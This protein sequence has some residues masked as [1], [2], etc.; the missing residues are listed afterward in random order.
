[1][2][3]NELVN[4]HNLPFLQG[5][6]EMGKI[7]R[8]TYWSET[9]LGPA[10]KWPAPLRLATS[11]VLSTPFPMYIAWGSDYIQIY[12]DG[13]RPILGS[14]KHPQAL[15]IST[16]ETFAEIWHIIGSMFDGVMG[17]EAVGFPDFMLPLNRNG[18]VEECF[19]DF[20]Y[21]PIRYEDRIVGGVLVTVIET[22][23]NKKNIS[24]LKESE[25][26]F[27]SLIQHAPVAIANLVGAN[28]VIESANTQILHYWG[29]TAEIIGMP[30][31][32][33]LPELKDQ[34]FL[35]I[36]NDTFTSGQTY[37][38]NQVKS[39]L[40]HEGQL[41][42][43]YFNFIYQP[44][45]GEDGLT[46]SIAVVANEVTELVHARNELGRTYEQVRLSKEAAMLGTFDMDLVKGTMMWDEQCRL[47][48]GIS[49]SNTV[50]YEKDFIPGLHPD[51]RERV[52]GVI[53]NTMNKAVSNGDYDVEY[54]TIGAESQQLR[55]VRAKGK[56]YFND[57]DEPI[58][59]IGSVLDITD[60]KTE[61]LRLNESVTRQA[62]LAA[63][64]DT[65][66]D[67]ILSKTLEGVITSWNKAAERMFGYTE[68]EAIGKH[69]SLIIP[70]SRLSEE[71][72]IIGQIK[73]GNRVDHFETVRVTK[74][75]RKIP[76]S[77]SVSPITD[78][79]GQIIGASKIA[80]D[81][82]AQYDAQQTAMRYTERLEI[83]NT[84]SQ[85]V[86]GEL[87][88][89]VILQKVT[90]ATTRLTG[91]AFG[92]FFYN[93]VDSKGESY[94]LYTLSGAPREA[95]EK[96]GMPRN[97]AIFNP[98]FEGEGIVRSDDITKDPR[99][100]K[101]AP[102]YG[103]P[104]G[105]LPVVS[106]LAVPVISNS[107]N[108][109]GG[110]FFGHPEPRMFTKE[111]ETLVS[112]IAA[113][114]AISI[115]NAKL[116]EEVKA[117]NQKKDEFIGLASHELKT[118]LTSISGYLQIISKL[119]TDDKT[120]QFVNKTVLQVRKLA[121]LVNDLLDVSKIEAGKLQLSV[122]EFDMVKLIEDTNEL[123]RLNSPKYD[124]EFNTEVGTCMVSADSQRIEQVLLNLLNNAIKYSPGAD[125]VVVTLR[126]ARDKVTVGVQDF[127]AGIPLDK[128]VQ[129]FS[130]FYR[131]E[132]TNPNIS[133]LG[134]GL[135][136]SAEIIARHE[137]K[138]WVE[139]EVGKG[140]TFYFSLP[141]NASYH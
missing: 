49:H 5:G 132:E 87:D 78:A 137:G 124:I 139:S 111:H 72:F 83:I 1:M 84:M 47:L 126:C 16:R 13:Y 65:S 121:T 44:I 41:I 28:L 127:G 116:F 33:A 11:I 18:F 109:I 35:Q 80:R 46:K 38:G 108:V 131:I 133:G 79:S 102:H 97:T 54:R 45:K 128:R 96:F 15:G 100:G 101:N 90:D 135:Y 94:M 25:M 39:L 99:Y 86:T 36:L 77:L 69:I 20:S 30:L 52:L 50:T 140:S 43:G 66:D 123:T 3:V 81:I 82:G 60:K 19:F 61:E 136:I 48:F 91:A 42:E 138:I 57:N 120:K 59:F 74:D 2:T 113:Q 21:S 89:N 106:Y 130:R 51:D 85:S 10:E 93:Q 112:S 114:A 71:D 9:P 8:E 129:I 14:T 4:N 119:Q 70:P 88:L 125:K 92:A 141:M 98:T 6:G 67:T 34:P 110:L 55:W 117:L 40:E 56:V 23:E 122:A 76:I 115:D 75:G 62:R 104:K 7:I 29:K 107:G 53:D 27:R 12:N 103:M 31:A 37:E 63:I 118:P 105:H 95:F 26:Q 134:I 17:G 68:E 64:I 32:Q 73:S 58:R 24:R 22:T